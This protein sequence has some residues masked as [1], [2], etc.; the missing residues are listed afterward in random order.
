M[1]TAGRKADHLRVSARADVAHA[2]GTGLEHVC[3]RHRALPKRDLDDVSLRV[4]LL[5]ARL[6]APLVVSAMTGG[7]AEAAEI[8]ARLARASCEHG[9][10]LVLGLG[11]AL[12]EDPSLLATYRSADRPP[13][14]PGGPRCRAGAGAGA[15]AGRAAR[16]A[17]RR[18]RA[19]RPPQPDSGGGAARG[20][21]QFAGVAAGVG[22]IVARLA[23]LP[24][25]AKEV[26][27]G[28]EPADVALLATRAWRRS[29]SP[30]PASR[31]GA[32]RGPPRRGGGAGRG[33][34]RRLGRVD[35]RIA[36]A[37]LRRGAGAAADRFR[38][39][40]GRGRGRQGGGARGDG[41]GARTPVLLAARADRTS[42]EAATLIRQLRVASWAAGTA[43]AGELGAEHLAP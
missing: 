16:G 23:P 2:G 28:M 8:N 5:G 36:G 1:M 39:A 7:T 19:D 18:R 32:G 43:G 11:R 31:T 3:L 37:R 24:V 41:G 42:A 38:G 27:F 40:A 14:L 34:V 10:A 20:A 21:P 13:L 22:A 6:G 4:D 29:T 30:A 35:G 26:G 12:L 25:V 17:A 9:L 15:G 33:G